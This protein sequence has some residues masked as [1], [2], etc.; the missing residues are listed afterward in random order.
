[1]ATQPKPY[2]HR[3]TSL[4]SRGLSRLVA[5]TDKDNTASQRTLEHAGFTKTRENED[6]FLYE[7]HV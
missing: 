2:G 7:F 1:M 3:A 4:V 6:L 5:D